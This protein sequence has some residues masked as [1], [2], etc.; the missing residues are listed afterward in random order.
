MGRYC[1]ECFKNLAQDKVEDIRR[2][3]ARHQYLW[4]YCPECF[5]ILDGDKDIE[6]RAQLRLN[7]NYHK[8]LLY[9]HK[10]SIGTGTNKHIDWSQVKQI[11]QD[12]N[13]TVKEAIRDLYGSRT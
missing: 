5:E 11:M 12:R 10:K 3:I 13:L 1:P 8:Y 7:P 6:V 4:N 2:K 9:K